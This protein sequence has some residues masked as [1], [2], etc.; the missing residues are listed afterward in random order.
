MAGMAEAG[1]NAG[2]GNSCKGGGGGSGWIFTKTNSDAGYTSSSYTGGIWQL[3]A[4]YY[5][6]KAETKSGDDETI[7]TYDGRDTM[8]GNKGN[9][10]AKISFIPK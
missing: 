4:K 2:N 1:G 3:G 7:P 6:T 10:L 5:L 9:G 8:I